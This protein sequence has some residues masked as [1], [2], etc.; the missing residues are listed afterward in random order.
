MSLEIVLGPMFSGK[1]TYALSFIRR[2]Q[3]I[4]KKIIVI[5]PD[6]DQRYSN[7]NVL[8]THDQQSVPCILWKTY[9]PLCEIPEMLEADCIVIEEAQFFRGLDSFVR[10][11]MEHYKKHI[12]IVGLDG[13]RMQRPFGEVLECIPWATSLKKLHALC[14]ECNDGTEAHYTKS[15]RTF[16]T[17]DQV[18]VGGI[19][20][21]SAVCLKHLLDK[22]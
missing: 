7:E 13:D 9:K 6:I 12:L 21:Y 8:V 20:K 2:Q 1:S 22:E 11:M 17:E 14:C 10:Y 3:I 16:D 4:K 18:S 5:K 19:D 15:T